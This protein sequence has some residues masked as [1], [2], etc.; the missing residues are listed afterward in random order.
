MVGAVF[1]KLG[2]GLSLLKGNRQIQGMQRQ[3]YGGF[4][5]IKFFDSFF[6]LYLD[7]FGEGREDVFEN[8][9]VLETQPHSNKTLFSSIH[10]S[11]ILVAL[12]S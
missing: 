3:G 2:R 5:V 8:L 12:L 7:I 6:L 11:S 9:I 1:G 10:L 4:S